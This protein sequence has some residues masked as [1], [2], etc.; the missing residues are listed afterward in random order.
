MAKIFCVANQK[1]GV[2]QTTTTVNLS[3]G[4]A[5]V[6]HCGFFKPRSGPLWDERGGCLEG[7]GRSGGPTRTAA[8][9]RAVASTW[10]AVTARGGDAGWQLSVWFHRTFGHRDFKSG[11][12]LPPR[13]PG[14]EYYAL[15]C[16]VFGSKRG[17][18][19]IPKVKI[20]DRSWLGSCRR[21]ISVRSRLTL[22]PNQTN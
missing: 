7:L 5:K 14:D 16:N 1:G 21:S 15:N 19:W 22:E 12:L 3:A 17:D 2:G 6:G 8:T 11:P 10:S 20:L 9:D 18:F 13:A 4:L